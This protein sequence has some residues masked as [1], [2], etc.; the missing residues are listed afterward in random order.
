LQVLLEDRF[1]LILR[2]ETKIQPVFLLKVAKSGFKPKD[3][4]TLPESVGSGFGGAVVSQ[5]VRR[6]VHISDLAYSLSGLLERHVIDRTDLTGS[7]SIVLEM[8]KE[9]NDPGGMVTI[10][11]GTAV[12]ALHDQLGLDLESGKEAVETFV[13]EHAERRTVEYQ[14]RLNQRL[15][16]PFFGSSPA[17]TA[18]CAAQKGDSVNASIDT[19]SFASPTESV[20]VAFLRAFQY[21]LPAARL[22]SF[23]L[24]SEHGR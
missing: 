6:G 19:I 5:L 15:A 20:G 7:Y 13:I 23:H 3:G 22:I 11:E 8:Q 14:A 16:A 21:T 18:T 4:G 24:S 17:Q 12:P 9:P 2:R 1:H 10:T